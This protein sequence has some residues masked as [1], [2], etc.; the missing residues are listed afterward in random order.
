[1]RSI[2]WELLVQ[3]QL[4]LEIGDLLSADPEAGLEALL[5]L[6]LEFLHDRGLIVRQ[7]HQ[8]EFVALLGE[9]LA[10]DLGC[11]LGLVALV[12]QALTNAVE[13][14]GEVHAGCLQGNEIVVELV[15]RVLR[16]D[17][18]RLQALERVHRVGRAVNNPSYQF[19]EGFVVRIGRLEEFLSDRKLLLL[20][21]V[22]GLARGV[23]FVERVTC[24][25][26]AAIGRI[27]RLR[28][29]FDRCL[30]EVA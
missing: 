29:S 24:L 15:G 27:E 3:L 9:Q 17:H 20:E 1:L 19:G 18:R 21:R 25:D 7:A 13:D 11:K 16:R 26:D 30:S 22:I 6:R 23:V 10:A 2:C 14:L 4:L 12:D 8:L 5:N 28:R